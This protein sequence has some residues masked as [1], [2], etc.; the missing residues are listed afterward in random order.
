MSRAPGFAG[1]V[2][3]KVGSLDDPAEFGGPEMVIYT[4]D[5]QPFHLVPEGVPTFERL[6]G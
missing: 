3:L 4:C 1:V 5:K 6:P 2:M